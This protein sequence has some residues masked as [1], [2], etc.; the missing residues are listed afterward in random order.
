MDK[1]LLCDL[2]KK[3]RMHRD[4]ANINKFTQGDHPGNYHLVMANKCAKAFNEDKPWWMFGLKVF[5]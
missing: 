1:I 4:I 5:K 3:H 2:K